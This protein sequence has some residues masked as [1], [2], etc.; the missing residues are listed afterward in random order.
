MLAA[1]R[2]RS[3]LRTT[4]RWDSEL[5]AALDA[6]GY[7]VDGRSA[8]LHEKSLALADYLVLLVVCGV[9][10][11]V[12]L[13][14]FQAE[15]GIRDSSVTGVQTCALPICPGSKSA[16]LPADWLPIHVILESATHSHG[17]SAVFM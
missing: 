1:A 13:V 6:R 3:Q 9:L 7:Q 5:V 17:A 14:F 15:D 2:A 10:L 8:R 12:L 11:A 4:V 16:S